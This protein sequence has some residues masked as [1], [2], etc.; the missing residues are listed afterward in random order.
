MP[1]NLTTLENGCRE[2][3]IEL[4]QKQKNQFIQFYE[5]LVEKNKVMNLTGITEYRVY[6]EKNHS[7]RNIS[8]S[9]FLCTVLVHRRKRADLSDR[10]TSFR[11]DST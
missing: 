8:P 6:R 7:E 5:F 11:R 9:P 1:Y 10:M 2:L 4:S 3:S